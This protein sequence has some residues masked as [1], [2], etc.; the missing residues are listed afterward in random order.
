VPTTNPFSAEEKRNKLIL[1]VADMSEDEVRV[2]YMFI[3]K[4]MGEGRKEYGPLDLKTE[5]RTLTEFMHEGADEVADG[6]FY[7]FVK[8]MM[9]MDQYD[10][11]VSM[12]EEK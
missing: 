12:H 8:M 9:Q 3:A 11:V 4:F 2:A 6:L 1:W 10:L 7:V 5:K